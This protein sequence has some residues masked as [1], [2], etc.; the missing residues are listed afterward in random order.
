MKLSNITKF[1]ASQPE[2]IV[3]GICAILLL[4]VLAV[5]LTGGKEDEAVSVVMNKKMQLDEVIKMNVPAVLG[6]IEYLKKIRSIWE[7]IQQ[8]V[9]GKSW[10]MYRP[11]VIPVKFEK[12]AIIP[13][14][15]KTNLSPIANGA[16]ANNE[17][18]DEIV[19]AWSGNISSTAQIKSYKVYRKAQGEK[20]FIV[21]IEIPAVTPTGSGYV[22]IDKG[23]KAEYSYWIT[24]LSGE[25]N[26]IKQ[27]SDRSGELK[28]TTPRDYS[29]EFISVIK[30][31]NSVYVKIGK[32]LNGKWDYMPTFINK[33]DKIDK[34]QFIT[35][36][37]FVDFQPDV[38][39]KSTGSGVVNKPTF[40]IIYLD[41]NGKEGS[42]LIEPK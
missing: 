22:H 39:P 12:I 14:D 13:P 21:I 24:A 23:L 34:D 11:P 3:F 30:E 10:L 19:L 36:W 29:I 35:G 28:V 16:K 17:K 40:R 33:G 32:Y 20:D 5:Y 41:R 37:T 15:K 27:E 6:P 25:Q 4:I 18:P 8:P 42:H 7:N 9:E 1:I 26:A 38:Y 2:R 31:K